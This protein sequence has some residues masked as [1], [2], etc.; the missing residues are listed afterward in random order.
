MEPDNTRLQAIALDVK[1]KFT[2]LFGLYSVCHMAFNSSDIVDV[3][4]LG[5]NI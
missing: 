5:M 1:E 2:S 4:L 3:S